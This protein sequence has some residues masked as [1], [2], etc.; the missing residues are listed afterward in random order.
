LGSPDEVARFTRS[1]NALALDLAARVRTA[2]GNI[3]LSP[4]AVSTGLVMLWAGARGETAAQIQKVLHAEGTSDG[5]VETAGQIAKSLSHPARQ[6]AFRAAARLFV[7]KSHPMEPA[8][9][10]RFARTF[11]GPVEALDF[12]S[13]SDAGRRHV[14]EWVSKQ[15]EGHIPELLPPSAVSPRPCASSPTR[16]TSRD[17]GGSTSSRK[18]RRSSLF[19]G[20]PPTLSGCP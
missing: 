7:D 19:I 20:R 9:Q 3:A 13:D 5:V 6:F 8:Y 16:S 17:G 12:A 1:N 15:T 10:K 2:P 14:N 18:R 4:F 11:G